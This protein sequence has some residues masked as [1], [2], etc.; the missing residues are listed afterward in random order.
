MKLLLYL[1]AAGLLSCTGFLCLIVVASVRFVRRRERFQDDESLPPVT[2]LK[3]L[4]GSEPN[5][6]ANIES[7]FQQ[8]YPKFEIIFGARH[9]SDPAL[10]IV[11]RM[12]RKYPAVPVRMVTPGEPDR[13]NAKVC[14]LQAMYAV[15]RHDYLVISDSDVQV[16][17]NYLR[18]VIGPLLD[19]DVGLVTCLYRGVPGDGFWSRLEAL[20]MSVEM[21]SGVL[22]ADL[23][24]GM[25]FALGPTMA[26]R[27]DV[28]EKIGGF[29]ALA[30]YCADDFVLG[31]RVHRWGGKV[32]LSKHVIDH[33][34]ISRTLRDSMAHQVRWMRSTRFSRPAGHV[35]TFLTYAM[36]FGIA[37][38]IA[39][40]HLHH[41]VLGALMFLAAYLNRVVMALVSGWKVVGDPRSLRSCWAYP[42]RDLTGFTVW[43]ASFF[44]SQI[45][46]R[47]EKY[48]LESGGRMVPALEF[49]NPP[50]LFPKPGLAKVEPD[51][52]GAI[53]A[54][55]D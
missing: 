54:R 51:I 21:T 53:R 22:A 31:E 5:L 20:G 32:V 44:G 55:P 8:Q 18:E 7:F 15:A 24:E 45:V 49:T 36:P 47:G 2:L 46:W 9:L 19:R 34:V 38:L 3:P 35:A 11:N 1:A 23:L 30:D 4:C 28:V 33:M 52:L 41:T 48:L 37:G 12:C 42:L 25:K 40:L 43:L 10:N 29:V 27:R 50:A 13:P 6:E 17:P 39:G 26:I 14:L 16:T